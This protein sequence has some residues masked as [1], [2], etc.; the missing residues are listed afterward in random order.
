MTTNITGASSIDDC[1][2]K[3]GRGR[4]ADGFFCG[5][6]AGTRYDRNQDECIPCEDNKYSVAGSTSCDCAHADRRMRI[7]PHAYSKEVYKAL[8]RLPHTP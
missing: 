7:G 8:H 3:K 1:Q 5:C 6:R 4:L 2:C